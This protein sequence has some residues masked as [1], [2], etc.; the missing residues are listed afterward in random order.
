MYDIF[1]KGA[2]FVGTLLVGAVTDAFT[3]YFEG[4]EEQGIQTAFTAQSIGVAALAVMFVIGLVLFIV[5]VR[6]NRALAPDT[7]AEPAVSEAQPS[8]GSSPEAEN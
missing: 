3:P 5:A 7:A 1:G 4:L 6:C 2:A 8:F